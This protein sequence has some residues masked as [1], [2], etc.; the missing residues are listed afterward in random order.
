MKEAA[1]SMFG[2]SPEQKAA[3]TAAQVTAAVRNEIFGEMA[4]QDFRN[5]L[6]Q[7]IQELKPRP[8]DAKQIREELSQLFDDTEIRAISTH[9]DRFDYDKLVA[10]FQKKYGSPERRE[11]AKQRAA[12]AV[13]ALKEEVQSDKPT[14][15]KVA[16]AGLRLAGLSKEE[17]EKTRHAW[18]EYLRKTGKEAL[19]PDSIKQ[20]IEILVHDP[21][22]G[23][24]LLQSRAAEAFNKSTVTELLAQ[25][26]DMSRE[27][28][29]RTADR[30]EQIIREFREK[31]GGALGGLDAIRQNAVARVRDYLNSM[32]RPEKKYGGIGDQISRLFH[33][34]K[35]EAEA[36]IRRFKSMDR[37]ELKSMIASRTDLSSEDADHLL[38]QIESTRDQVVGKVEQMKSEV[39][40][41]MTQLKEEGLRQAEETRKVVASAAWWTFATAV[42]S[43]VAAVFGGLAGV[44]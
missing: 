25:R 20:E 32:N 35:G 36:L 16:D 18:E 34:P 29:E 23:A 28:A 44:S 33:D 21:K 27:E 41:R 37:E 12:G 22:K 7:F 2:S 38:N 43:A 11:A 1:S 19:N 40:R 31:G 13:S 4:P 6:H 14:A 8:I 5:Q 26:E 10:T 39:D 9:D 15:E 17:A 24:A 30:A 3:D 42:F